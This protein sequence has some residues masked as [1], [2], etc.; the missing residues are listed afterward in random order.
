MPGKMKG[1]LTERIAKCDKVEFEQSLI[2]L[3]MGLIILVYLFYRYITLAALTYSDIIALRIIGIFLL[4]ALILI[5]SILYGRKTSVFRRLAGAWLDI[6]TTTLFMALTGEVGVML[7]G[8]YLWVIFGNGFRF[9]NKSVV[10]GN[11]A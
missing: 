2:R 1:W 3:G 11:F 9:G 8:I 4:L 5:G 7:V 10:S 6:G